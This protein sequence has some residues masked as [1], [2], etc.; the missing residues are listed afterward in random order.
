MIKAN[1]IHVGHSYGHSN[2]Q[3]LGHGPTSLTIV[4]LKQRN[5]F[6]FCTQLKKHNMKAQLPKAEQ[7]NR[8]NQVIGFITEP[9]N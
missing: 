1:S 2:W 9:L 6:Y 7:K 4:K 8:K 3:K 5:S